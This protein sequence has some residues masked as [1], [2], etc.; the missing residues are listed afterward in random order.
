MGRVLQV[1]ACC[2]IGEA[3][4][5]HAPLLG[6]GTRG[7]ARVGASSSSGDDAMVSSSPEG[8]RPSAR[9]LLGK[10]YELAVPYFKETSE[11]RW[12][13]ARVVGLTL[14][15]SGVSVV[16]SYLSRD[17]YNALSAKDVAS[18]RD[19]LLKF[20]GALA[21]GVPVTVL[22][23][24]E[25]ET[26]ALRWRNW[27]TRDLLGK[28]C[29]DR[30]F[31]EVEYNSTIDNPDQRI[32]EDAA[33]FA[34][35]SLSFGI[36]ALTSIVDLASFS[37]ILY[38]IY[39]PLF[40]AIVV[41]ATLGSVLTAYVGRELPDRNFR[42]LRRE[43][44]FR[45][46]L[47]RLRENAEAVAFYDGAV[48][49]RRRAQDRLDRAVDAQ[50]DVI[51]TQRN[52]EF[53]TVAYR[54]LVQVLPV[55]V[56]AP[57]YFAGE[58]ELG[59]VTQSSSSFNHVLSDLSAIV[60][61]YEAIAAFGAGLDRLAAFADTLQRDDDDEEEPA[62]GKPSSPDV[63]LETRSLAVQTPDGTK[64]LVDDLDLELRLGQRL[65]ITGASGAGKSSVLRTLA[66][67]WRP[68][69]GDVSL[70]DRAVFLPQK[71]YC[72][73]GSLRDQLLLLNTD[74]P[75][76]DDHLLHALE[77]VG[78]RALAA[79]DPVQGLGVTKDWASMLSLGEQQRLAFARLVLN[80]PKLAVLDE[81]TSALDL[82][83]E[84]RM[85]DLLKTKLGDDLA[86]V[87]VGHRPSLLQ[88]HDLRLRLDGTT[89]PQLE[90]ITDADRR[91]AAQTSII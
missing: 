74:D 28:Y 55:A 85:Y 47:V 14:L 56:V 45:Y 38:S 25:R 66:S 64:A 17:F 76:D 20:C 49:E 65:L 75:I 18:F 53:V 37:T 88:H 43:A 77:L 16:F 39:P 24:F 41:Y 46:A 78:L 15:Q 54:F 40:G 86:V 8:E 62:A 58:V 12:L 87:S 10:F 27:L 61:Q 30:K 42:A 59:V 9:V 23:R 2:A 83:T 22:Y 11:A 69:S 21:A 4:V 44:D 72:S 48:P 91:A 81:A 3:L 35:V 32:S 13:L 57:L 1:V 90:P 50:A 34:A 29:V 19:I 36:T 79:I 71:P 82:D 67:L 7:I 63:V 84:R 60:T 6:R 70:V 26:L 33:A 31:Y 89:T 80:Q 73:L 68:K 52:V 5:W 51:R